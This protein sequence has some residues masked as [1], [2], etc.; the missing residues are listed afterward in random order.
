MQYVDV[1]LDVKNNQSQIVWELL[2][3]MRPDRSSAMREYHEK[4]LQFLSGLNEEDKDIFQAKYLP[5]LELDYTTWLNESLEPIFD[6]KTINEAKQYPYFGYVEIRSH[7]WSIMLGCYPPPNTSIFWTEISLLASTSFFWINPLGYR[8]TCIQL[9]HEFAEILGSTQALYFDDFGLNHEGV[10]T[11][12]GNNYAFYDYYYYGK[13]GGFPYSE[14][15][16]LSEFIDRLG[17]EIGPPL[18]MNMT[19]PE[20]ELIPLEKQYRAYLIERF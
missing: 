6:I 17:K 12:Y 1:I 11:L 4:A 10:S 19:Y 5:R 16:P 13:E 9:I 7:F 18:D 20:N 14:F 8:Q 3:R 2:E 15:I